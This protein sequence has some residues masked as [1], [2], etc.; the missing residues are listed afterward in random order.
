MDWNK[1]FTKYISDN[2][3]LFRVYI[4]KIKPYSSIRKRQKKFTLKVGKIFEYMLH[5]KKYINIPKT[6][7]KIFIISS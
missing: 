4:Y 2:R 6:H 1:I 3:L 5:K 7:E